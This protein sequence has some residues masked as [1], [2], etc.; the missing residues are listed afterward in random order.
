M[1]KHL[2][3]IGTLAAAL[4]APVVA[5]ADPIAEFY[6]AKK[7]SIVIGQSPGGS[8]DSYGRMIGRHM[9]KYLPGNP[10]FV[11]QN[12]TGAGGRT[13]TAWMYNIAP[14]DGTALAVISQTIPMD[15]VVHNIPSTQFD[16]R[17]FNWI[18]NPFRS[19][20]VLAVWHT[21]GVRT[22][23]DAKQREVAIGG[24]GP[25][26]P[27]TLYP[28]VSNAMFGTK[29]KIIPGY[30]GG[31]EIDL[32]MERGEVG[33][34]G[35][36]SW[37]SMKE[38]N[39]VAEKKL[40]VLFQIGAQ[41]E[42]DLSTVPLLTDLARNADDRVM[43]EFISSSLAMGRPLLTTPAVPPERVGALRRAFDSTMKD[44]DFLR[45]ARNQNLD[46]TP[47]S[48]EALQALVERTIATPPTI[49]A[50]VRE[51]MQIKAEAK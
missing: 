10:V 42:P 23:E 14:K 3:V 5:T 9:G 17:Q 26:S 6:K 49:V 50:R 21:S 16:A 28:R 1:I 8:Y 43:L 24:T 12:M 11:S 47:V 4:T 51:L 30:A 25:T 45:E 41:R 27:D 48:G 29:F 20:N 15:Q 46:V 38:T 39:W 18:G 35:S 19:N 32:A 36:N 2:A 13:A 34:R 22:I 44:A 31:S 37:Q 33:G 7:M 40:Y